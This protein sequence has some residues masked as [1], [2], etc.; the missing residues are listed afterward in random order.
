MPDASDPKALNPP[1]LW[2]LRW[3]KSP[4]LPERERFLLAGEPGDRP[5]HRSRIGP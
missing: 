5:Q 4:G 1:T 3:Q 2:T